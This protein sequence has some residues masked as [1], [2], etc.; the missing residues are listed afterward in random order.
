ML[1]VGEPTVA[2]AGE[3]V[4]ETTGVMRGDPCHIDVVD[5]WGN[6]VAATPSGGW[7]QSSPVVPGLGFSLPTRAQ[8]FWLDEGL[9]R[10]LRPGR[11][12]RPTLTPSLALQDGQ[13]YLAWGTPGGDKQIRSDSSRGKV[14]TYV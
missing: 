5:R 13:P 2:E 3:P 7:F 8:M 12:P 4:S 1:G 11:R 14:V 9:P 6:M 10:T